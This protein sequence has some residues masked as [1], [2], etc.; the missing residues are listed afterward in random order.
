MSVVLLTQLY[1]FRD[2]RT[3]KLKTKK[4]E[5]LGLLVSIKQHGLDLGSAYVGDLGNL[6]GS[7]GERGNSV[8][9]VPMLHIPKILLLSP[10]RGR[11][12]V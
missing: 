5:L 9:A 6:L 10:G 8:L 1:P 2:G 11:M 7:M 3:E 12:L 4:G